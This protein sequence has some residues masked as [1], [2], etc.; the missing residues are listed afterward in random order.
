MNCPV[1]IY[2]AYR[3]VPHLPQIFSRKIYQRAIEDLIL[4][5]L[6]YIRGNKRSKLDS[7]C[8]L[9]RFRIVE[10]QAVVFARSF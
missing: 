3:R 5:L 1:A 10:L 7:P 2:P 6:Y 9:A 8:I 4:T